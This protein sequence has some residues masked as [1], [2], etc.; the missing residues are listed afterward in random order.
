MSG[1]IDTAAISYH[2]WFASL[3]RAGFN[4]EQAVYL[5]GQALFAANMVHAM[6][7]PR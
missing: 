4:E 1:V 6:R 3:I 2:E 7:Q 5:V